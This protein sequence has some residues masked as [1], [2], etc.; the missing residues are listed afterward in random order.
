MV[1]DRP[2]VMGILN[3]TP[4]SFYD[5][6]K[7]FSEKEIIIQAEKLLTDGADFIDIGGYSTRPGAEHI[8]L[9][10]ELRRSVG[11]VKV[12]LKK[13]PE[14][15][16]SIDSFRSEIVRAAVGEGAVMVNDVSGGELDPEMF[17]VVAALNVPYVLMHMRGNPKTMINLTAYD[18]VVQSVIDYF[19]P[20]VHKLTQLGVKDIIL[21]PGFGFAKTR[22]QNFE[23]LNKLDDFKIFEKPILV[24]LSRKSMVWKTLGI[25][26]AEA[27]N[28]TTA[29]HAI[30]LYNG[31]S[32][33]RA[34][35]VKE[36]VEVVKLVSEL[37]SNS[38]A[39]V[40]N[41]GLR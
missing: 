25:S 21:D 8:S 19:H 34:H 35:D 24:G 6:G 13:F 3:V 1:L 40:S 36:C 41:K 12:L 16:I 32:I 39:N 23:M 18:D 14:A 2:R 30:A 17:N 5:G 11:A 38:T 31:A 28:G 29:L 15:F 22:E 7:Y 37:W 4:D 10:E 33:I 9:E 20:K 27:L 26:A